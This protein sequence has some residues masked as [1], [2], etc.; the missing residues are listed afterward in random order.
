MHA[1]LFEAFE[2]LSGRLIG[3]GLLHSLWVGLCVAA[4]LS[5]AFQICPNL[6]HQA[7]YLMLVF[8]FFL[9]EGRRDGDRG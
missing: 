1:I 2:G 7:R 5:L 4:L 6:S 8:A 3:L 9:I